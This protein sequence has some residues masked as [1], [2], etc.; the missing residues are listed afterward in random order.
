MRASPLLALLMAGPALAQDRPITTPT[1]DVDVNYR[2]EVRGQV[3][4]ERMRFRAADRKARTD[5]P[6]PGTYMIADYA[7]GRMSMVSD[8]E[9]ASLDMT[10]RPGAM[11]GDLAAGQTFTRGGNARVAGVECTEWQTRDRSGHEA[12]ACFTPDGVMLR[13]RRGP[14]AAI[15]ATKVVYGPLD[16]AIFVVPPGYQHAAPQNTAPQ[17][18]R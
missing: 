16:S 2:I 3:L 12:T 5:L 15:E 6:T 17:N 13:A 1:R 4:T 14:Q 9:R 7:A 8:A 18:R 10:L 11:P